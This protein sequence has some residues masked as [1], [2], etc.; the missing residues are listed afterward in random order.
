MFN[1]KPWLTGAQAE[2]PLAAVATQCLTLLNAM[3]AP[4]ADK[5]G[6]Q[7]LITQVVNTLNMEID[8]VATAIT[9]STRVVRPLQMFRHPHQRPRPLPYL[10]TTQREKP[11]PPRAMQL[12]GPTH[13]P[14]R[15]Q[16]H[17][18][19][20]VRERPWHQEPAEAGA[21]RYT[22]H[23]NRKAPPKPPSTATKDWGHG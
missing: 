8:R 10:P 17:R 6:L 11:W 19:L 2:G 18:P 22:K 16:W 14:L 4:K 15:C 1:I 5:T 23:P 9:P 21:Y 7:A 3:L 12:G 13:S 20:T